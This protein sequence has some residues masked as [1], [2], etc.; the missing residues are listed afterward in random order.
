MKVEILIVDS[1]DLIYILNLRCASNSIRETLTRFRAK[2]TVYNSKS[3][4]LREKFSF[5]FIRNPWDRLLSVFCLQKQDDLLLQALAASFKKDRNGPVFQS[6][7]L[8]CETVCEQLDDRT[9]KHVMTQ[10]RILN[11]LKQPIDFI[12]RFENLITDWKYLQKMFPLKDLPLLFKTEHE[13]YSTYYTDFM[14][15]IVG[16]HFRDDVEMF[17]YC[18][19]DMRNGV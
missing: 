17:N 3:N 11:A 5:T 13:H 15:D 1:L 14:R 10:A 12:G 4:I 19:K 18:F 7:R 2:R 6:F 9:N 16:E 8:F